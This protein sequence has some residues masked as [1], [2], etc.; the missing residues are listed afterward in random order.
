[1]AVR[2]ERIHYLAGGIGGLV[3]V[4]LEGDGFREEVADGNGIW[5]RIGGVLV[6]ETAICGEGEEDEIE[7]V[8]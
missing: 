1:M 8:D 3:I 6:K 4:L 5:G 7:A 2:R